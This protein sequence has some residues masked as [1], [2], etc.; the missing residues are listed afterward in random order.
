[1]ES[2]RSYGERI[3]YNVGW[4]G[5]PQQCICTILGH[6]PGVAERRSVIEGKRGVGI[7]HKREGV[8]GKLTFSMKKGPKSGGGRYHHRKKKKKLFRLRD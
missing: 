1:V 4:V 2:E 7:I 3:S 5:A 6:F 8:L